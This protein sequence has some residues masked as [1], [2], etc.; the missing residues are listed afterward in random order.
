MVIQA[1]NV[2]QFEGIQALVFKSQIASNVLEDLGIDCSLHII[3]IWKRTGE[4]I[5]HY[6]DSIT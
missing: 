3:P 6:P 5:S 2:H 4:L 1:N